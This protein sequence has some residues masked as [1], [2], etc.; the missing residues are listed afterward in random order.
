MDVAAWIVV[1]IFVSILWRWIGQ[2]QMKDEIKRDKIAQVD[3]STVISQSTDEAIKRV[4]DLLTLQNSQIEALTSVNEQKLTNIGTTVEN[5]LSNAFTAVS[6]R[7]DKVHEGLGQMNALAKGVGDLKNVLSNVKTRGVWGEIQLERLL[8]DILTPDQY[9]LNVRI[10][11]DSRDVVE[12]VVNLPEGVMLPIDAKFPLADYERLVEAYKDPLLD[13]TQL[14][15]LQKALARRVKAEAKSI[16]DKYIYP[17]KT[18]DFAIL[19]VPIESLYAEI[20]RVPGFVEE[21]QN[22]YRIVVSGPVTIA[23]LLNSLQMGFRTLAIEK[24]SSEVWELLAR[25]KLEFGKFGELLEKSQKKLQE[26]SNSIETASSK[27]RSIESKLKKIERLPS[28]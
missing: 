27:S 10:R 3:M 18:T 25:I 8:A 17:P 26:A 23:A 12:F 20:L 5:T 15:G 6:A 24:S 28:P 4:T 21:L 19:F 22:E 13:K 1:I 16:H 9:S 2:K 14:Q 11:D 7:L